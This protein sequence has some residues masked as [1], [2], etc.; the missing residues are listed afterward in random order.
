MMFSLI[1]SWFQWITTDMKT[2]VC[3]HV[4]S[5]S[6]ELALFNVLLIGMLSILSRPGPIT[7]QPGKPPSIVKE[8]THYV[9]GKTRNPG[10]LH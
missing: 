2:L 6:T 10:Q 1:G 4:L 7:S 9:E 8:K 5:N 3:P